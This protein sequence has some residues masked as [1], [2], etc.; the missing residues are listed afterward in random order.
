MHRRQFLA[1]T[2]AVAAAP[3]LLAADPKDAKMLP[4]IDTHQHLWDLSKL[5]LSWLKKGSEFDQSFTPKEYAAAIDGQN[6]VKSVYMEVDVVPDQQQAEAD[7]VCE[8]CESKKTT[9]VAAVIGG[10]PGAADFPAYLARYKDNKY[11]KGVRQVLHADSTPSGYAL[12]DEF[13]KG[14]QLLGDLGLIFDLCLRP[15]DLGDACKLLDKCPD[16]R[17]VLDHCG[18]P[19]AD[20]TAKQIDDW[21]A[22]LGEVAKRKNVMVKVSGIVANGWERGRWKAEELAPAV[23]ATIEAFG[24]ARCLYGGDWPVCTKAATYAEWITAL[25]QIISS[26]PEADQKKILHDNA[27]KFYGI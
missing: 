2:A 23:N 15:T 4:A 16:T 18:N 7:Y 3:L 21:K 19:Q 14:V 11:V 13:V 22:A 24:V 17:F 9:M 1:T 5:K 25:R 27:A 20:F 10:R 26:R 6:V 8:L 12:K